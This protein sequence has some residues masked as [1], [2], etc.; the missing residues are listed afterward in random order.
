MMLES[1]VVFPAPF[2]PSSATT[3][4]RFTSSEMPKRTWLA[5]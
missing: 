5:P 3:S 1:V 4:P 2:L